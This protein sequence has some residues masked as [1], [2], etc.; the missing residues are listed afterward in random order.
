[1]KLASVLLLA[2]PFDLGR[3]SQSGPHQLAAGQAYVATAQAG[4]AYVPGAAA[5]Q[6]RPA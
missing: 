5:A 2:P 3:A 6:A 1:M 4:Q